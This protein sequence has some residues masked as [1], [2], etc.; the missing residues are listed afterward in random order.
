M[1]E[2]DNTNEADQLR[3][4][5]AIQFI[6][7]WVERAQEEVVHKSSMPIKD[8][9]PALFLLTVQA[10]V[11]AIDFPDLYRQYKSDKE[12]LDEQYSNPETKGYKLYP[13]ESKKRLNLVLKLLNDIGPLKIDGRF[14]YASPEQEDEVEFVGFEDA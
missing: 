3:P 7:E 6:D 14:D 11:H 13:E 9:Y 4:I 12:E 5:P 1:S 8:Y 10:E 2:I